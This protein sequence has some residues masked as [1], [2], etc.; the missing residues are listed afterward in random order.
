MSPSSCSW[1][2]SPAVVVPTG[3]LLRR[4]NG[5]AQ[6]RDGPHGCQGFRTGLDS[7]SP[8]APWMALSSP[9]PHLA[10][11]RRMR[12]T[13]AVG[14]W[15]RG[16]SCRVPGI[17]IR[18]ESSPRIGD[19]RA[20]GSVPPAIPCPA[21]ERT[22]N[23]DDQGWRQDPEREARPH[24]GERA[25]RSCRARSCSAAR[26]SS[27]SRCRARSPPRAPPPT[28]PAFVANAD[29]I[30]AKGVDDVVCLSV[31]D[32]FV[33]GCVGQGAERRGRSHGGRR[34]RRVR[35]GGGARA[36]SRRPR[37]RDALPAPT[38][39]W[40]RTA[41]SPICTWMSPPS[42]TSRARSRCSISSESPASGHS[43]AS[44]AGSRP[45]PARE[46]GHDFDSSALSSGTAWNRSATRP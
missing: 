5:A 9:R 32:A 18:S 41:P 3:F 14:P 13:L 16:R 37:P 24:D 46:I 44:R 2:S 25:G 31:N 39:W 7:I 27:C 17:R 26:R 33:D 43:R 29:K 11:G 23:D 28:C 10:P 12:G 1:R 4:N 19:P 36:R 45:H 30:K 34:Q 40:W 8:P 20:L 42:S 35:P 21:N 22:T 38:R 15:P 6:H